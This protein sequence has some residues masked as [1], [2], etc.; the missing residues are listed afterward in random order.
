MDPDYHTSPCCICKRK[1]FRLWNHCWYCAGYLCTNC[2]VYDDAKDIWLC[3]NCDYDKEK[4]DKAYNKK[5]L[6]NK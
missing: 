2:F 5:C 6:I 4:V 1:V 3:I